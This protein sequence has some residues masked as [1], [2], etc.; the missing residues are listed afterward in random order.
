MSPLRMKIR[1][2][3]PLL[4]LVVNRSL[5]NILEIYI[6]LTIQI[7]SSRIHRKHN[8]CIEGK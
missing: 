2:N 6:P 5:L 4:G 1:K 3:W 8:Q 7:V